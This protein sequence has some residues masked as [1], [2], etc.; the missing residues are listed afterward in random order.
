VLAAWLPVLLAASLR[1]IQLNAGLALEP[2]LEYSMPVALAL[3]ALVLTA[4]LA[5]RMLALRRERD[6]TRLEVERDALTGADNRHGLTRR[7][8]YVFD[9]ARA[10]ARPLAL[11]FLD[12]DRFKRVNDEHGHALGDQALRA[13]VAHAREELRGADVLG[14]YGGEEFVAVLPGATLAQARAVAER[15][16]ANVER[17][18][19]AIDGRV[20]RL[21]VS[22]GVVEARWP[23]DTP[24]R[25][26][27]RA[28]AAMYAAKRAGRNRVESAALAEAATAGG[29]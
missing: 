10:E 29:A 28:D 20:V 15:I 16:R 4:G 19:A 3:G 1:S 17:G 12:L 23:D 13:V 6:R 27:A 5:D 26:L 22:I 11:L 18:C 2:W 25:L 24:E 8:R 9:Q 14:R 21:T 7:L